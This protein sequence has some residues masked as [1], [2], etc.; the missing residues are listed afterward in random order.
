MRCACEQCKAHDA[1]VRTREAE[2]HG[3]TNHEHRERHVELHRALDE[4]MADWF[5]H[6]PSAGIYRE[7]ID[8]ATWSN[9]QQKNP[10]GES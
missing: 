9:E 3:L 6:V 10:T 5:R 1:A 8:L 7:V 4:L 2:S